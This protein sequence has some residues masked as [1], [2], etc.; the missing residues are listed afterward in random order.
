MKFAISGGGPAGLHF[1]Y[2]VKR[3]HPEHEVTVFEQSPRS[4]T[5]G[6][7]IVFT[8]LK[9]IREFDPTFHDEVLARQKGFRDGM[10]IVHRGVA[11]FVDGFPFNRMAR[12]DLLNVLQARCEAVGVKL[13]FESRVR[14]HEDLP[15]ADVVVIA[16]GVNSSMRDQFND[17]FGTRRGER[18]FWWAW[19][20][21]EA[22]FSATTLTFQQHPDGLYIGHAYQYAPDRS[23]FVVEAP[24]ATWERAGFAGMD[25]ERTRLYCS[26]VFAD[27]LGGK[28]LLSNRTVWFKYPV[29]TN[30][31]WS[32]RNMVLIGDCMRTG[33]PT[34]GA[35]TRLA[36]HDA[37]HLFQ[38]FEQHPSD[39]QAAFAAFEQSRR[40]GS[41]AMVDVADRSVK[42]YESVEARLSLDPVAFTYSYMMRTGRITHEDLRQRDPA[43]IARYEALT[44]AP[45]H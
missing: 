35:G 23:A 40:P 22:L 8:D 24:P 45:T 38:A 34:I 9:F 19:Y 30:E 39:V 1:A 11:T 2:L 7:G 31:R 28:P 33:H 12:I 16:E 43:F 3:A 21:T 17:H 15:K 4:A 44:T 18:S 13:V 10:Q 32:H 14:S 26:E 5:Y 6:F 20:G 37:Q 25:E 36:M 42:W 29:I 27:A 41:N